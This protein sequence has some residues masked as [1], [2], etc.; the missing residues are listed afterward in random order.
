MQCICLSLY[1][2]TQTKSNKTPVHVGE[3]I[4]ISQVIKLK[5]L[6]NILCGTQVKKQTLSQNVLYKT[7]FN[8]VFYTY[9][10]YQRRT[11]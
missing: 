2:Q 8:C 9:K 10:N 4:M 1:T 7:Y 11:V 6:Y 3:N 5:E